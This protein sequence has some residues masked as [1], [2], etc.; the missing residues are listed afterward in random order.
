V[1]DVLRRLA[2]GAAFSAVALPLDVPV[3]LAGAIV[4]VLS[5]A[6]PPPGGLT[7]PWVMAM[8]FINGGGRALLGVSA[9]LL[10]LAVAGRFKAGVAKS[11]SCVHHV[12]TS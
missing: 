2:W 7:H 4:D 12:V 1:R 11:S 8:N 10:A 3:V 5:S 9:A 6:M